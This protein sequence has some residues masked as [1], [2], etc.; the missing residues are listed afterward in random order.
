ML[1]GSSWML[2]GGRLN[3][4][5]VPITQEMF[6]EATAMERDRVVFSDGSVRNYYKVAN[7]DAPE[8]VT[9]TQLARFVTECA[10]V[11]VHYIGGPHAAQEEA[12]VLAVE[13]ES[14]PERRGS[15]ERSAQS[16]KII[17]RT[18]ADIWHSLTA[19][20]D[21]HKVPHSN[22]RVGRYGPDLRTLDKSALL[23]EIK[24]SGAASDLQTGIGQLLLY[25]QLLGRDHRKVLVLPGSVSPGVAKALK[26]LGVLH[27][28]FSRTGRSVRFEP[29]DISRLLK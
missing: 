26:K 6:D 18:H 15:Y 3:P 20:L 7:I 27:L 28:Q 1:K 24:S 12:D 17:A 9:R 5:G 14:S 4:S 21:K 13:T 22:G 23:F 25:E 11:R 2:H 8:T 16:A 10:R 19:L 29:A